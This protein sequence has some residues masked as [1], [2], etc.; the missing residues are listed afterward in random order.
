MNLTLFSLAAFL[1]LHSTRWLH[2]HYI[3]D[4]LNRVWTLHGDRQLGTEVDIIYDFAYSTRMTLV[5]ARLTVWWVS[6]Q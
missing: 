3:I 2:H 6:R 4:L 1:G 5:K